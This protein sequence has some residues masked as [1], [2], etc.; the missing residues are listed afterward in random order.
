[1]LNTQI[2]TSHIT[3]QKTSH[4][5]SHHIVTTT[6]CRLCYKHTVTICTSKFNSN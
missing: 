6:S 3:S 5:T 2:I 1:M 4:H